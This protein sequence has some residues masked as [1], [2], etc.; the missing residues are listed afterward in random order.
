V[1]GE[2]RKKTGSGTK[3]ENETLTLTRLGLVYIS[4]DV[5]LDPL[6]KGVTIIT[7]G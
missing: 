6:H 5:G 7:R 2:K 3:L 4:I 1:E